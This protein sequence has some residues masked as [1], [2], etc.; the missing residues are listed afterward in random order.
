MYKLL[1]YKL[2]EVADDENEQ[3]VKFKEAMQHFN[4]G[5]KV[6]TDKSD[7]V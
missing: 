1:Q 4:W 2:L 6:N 5:K 3:P 7:T